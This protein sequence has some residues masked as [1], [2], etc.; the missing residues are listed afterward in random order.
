MI[1]S[2]HHIIH[3]ITSIFLYYIISAHR[4][5]R[6]HWDPFKFIYMRNLLFI[7]IERQ[8]LI[9]NF[10][11]KNRS[12]T[13]SFK[14]HL[15]LC[16]CSP[17]FSSPLSAIS[18]FLTVCKKKDMDHGKRQTCNYRVFPR[19]FPSLNLILSFSHLMQSSNS[20]RYGLNR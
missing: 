14:F 5:H 16:S 12:P 1:T 10:T 4:T 8:P 15:T 11:M 17:P 19:P 2:A 18:N 13:A 20:G 3:Y 6:F 7:S 9:F